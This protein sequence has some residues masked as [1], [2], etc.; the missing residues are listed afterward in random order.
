MGLIWGAILIHCAETKAHTSTKLGEVWEYEYMGKVD[1]KQGK[2][3][4]GGNLNH[5]RY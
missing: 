3:S 2:I 5:F 4:S 1:Q